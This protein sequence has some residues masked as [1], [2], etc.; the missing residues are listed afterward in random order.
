[1]SALN[2]L[3]S[4]IYILVC[5]EKARVKEAG[6]VPEKKKSAGLR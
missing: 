2:R 3:S 1:V 5:L 4:I 6:A